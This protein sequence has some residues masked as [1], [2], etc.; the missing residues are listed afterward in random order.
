M[1]VIYLVGA[2][3][4]IIF[5][6]G[7][8][9]APTGNIIIED[10]GSQVEEEQL[11]EAQPEETEAAEPAENETLAEEAAN[12]SEEEAE[13]VNANLIE[14][15]DLTFNPG[16]LT[17]DKGATVVWKHNDRHLDRDDVRHQISII[18]YP[19]SVRSDLLF[20]GDKFEYTFDKEGE[21]I[22]T[23]AVYKEGLRGKIIV[24]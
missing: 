10:I 4:L 23:D 19:Y 12:I 20:F 17:V 7:C 8:A 9:K 5:I 24:R 6:S 21:Y 15:K 2:F 18:M 13:P 14:I 16:E 11:A 3:L 1:K 22:F